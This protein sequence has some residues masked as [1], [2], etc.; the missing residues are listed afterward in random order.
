MTTG[1]SRG[2]SASAV[3][4]ETDVLQDLRTLATFGAVGR[5]VSR[6]AFSDP[7]M[8]ARRWLAE[9][10][11][12]AG[13][14]ASVD[15]IG[16]VLGKDPRA[17]T[18]LLMGS[19]SD[20]VPRGG[21]LDG[22]LGVIFAFGAACAWRAARPRSRVGIDV[23]S[24]ADEEGTFEGCIGSRAFCGLWDGVPDGA[25]TPLALALRSAGLSGRPGHR[26]DPARHKAYLEAHIEQG[27]RLEEEGLS[28]GVVEG[29]VGVRRQRVRFT[30]RA[31]HAGT[32]P[33]RSR[34]D[35]GR[36]LITFCATLEAAFQ[37]SAAPGAVWNMGVLS[38]SPGAANVV[39][40][41]AEVV[42]EYR[43]LDRAAIGAMTDLV[44]KAA[45]HSDVPVTVEEVGALEPS[46]MDL[47]LQAD[48]RAAAAEVGASALDLPSG[49]GH[50]AMI[51]S[52]VMPSAM[53]FVPSI[54]GRSHDPAEDTSEADLERGYRVFLAWAFRVLDRLE[55]EAA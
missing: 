32:T 44:Q 36:A 8:T 18:T 26:Q 12:A 17:S 35:A 22:A 6:P 9:R 25:T 15:G 53:M 48:L 54:G 7:D 4:T 14:E 42:V 37:G 5:G 21:W 38:V 41:S 10:F 1:A 19:H 24:F 3:G 49:A 27:P 30:G 43:H 2:A 33:M 55:R 51:L 28:I 23:I 47:A 40:R 20:T 46:A 16:N 11:G 31:D 39:P 50:D 52:R 13:L 34:R 45:E 29:I